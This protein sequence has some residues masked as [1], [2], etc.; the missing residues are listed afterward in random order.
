MKQIVRYLNNDHEIVDKSDATMAIAQM[1]D[2]NGDVVKETFYH[3][4]GG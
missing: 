3:V 4:F 1:I 2:D